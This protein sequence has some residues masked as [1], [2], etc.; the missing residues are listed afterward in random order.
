MEVYEKG[1]LPRTLLPGQELVAAGVLQN[2]VPVEALFDRDAAHTVVL[3]NLLQRHGYASLEEVRGEGREEGRE[4]GRAEGREVGR[5]EGREA[6]REEALRV[7]IRDLA[8]LLEL[9]WDDARAA[10]IASM[11]GPALDE[12]R[13]AIVRDRRWP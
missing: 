7:A 2:P 6:G 5:E 9:P 12:L 11:R 1:A 10:A 4:A 8:T 13:R 3:R